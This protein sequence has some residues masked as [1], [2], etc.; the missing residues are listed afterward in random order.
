MG[1]GRYVG[2]RFEGKRT[3]ALSRRGR[4]WQERARLDGTT[5]SAAR[6]ASA[7]RAA[8]TRRTAAAVIEHLGMEFPGEEE[9]GV[10]RSRSVAGVNRSPP[11][12]P[13][14]AE[15]QPAPSKRPNRCR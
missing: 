2:Q 6:K 7:A 13:N 1:N 14:A 4:R 8:A 9:E 10:G 11:K 5:S 12:P 15:A 3:T